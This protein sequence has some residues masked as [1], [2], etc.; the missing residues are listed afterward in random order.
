[1]NHFLYSIIL[2]VVIL[3]FLFVS[4]IIDACKFNG[5]HTSKFVGLNL[6]CLVVSWSAI[7]KFFFL[8]SWYNIF[9][10]L[11]IYSVLQIAASFTVEM[12]KTNKWICFISAVVCEIIGISLLIYLLVI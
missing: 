12:P 10:T 9:Y 7:I 2:S 6:I 4:Y 8:Y 1:M 11:L 5:R 3:M